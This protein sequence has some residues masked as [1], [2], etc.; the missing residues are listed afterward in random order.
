VDI[1]TQIQRKG[2]A[3]FFEGSGCFR[4]RVFFYPIIPWTGFYEIMPE[5]QAEV[6]VFVEFLLVKE[7]A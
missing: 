6:I 3:L 2:Q 4:I 7:S 5:R 1:F